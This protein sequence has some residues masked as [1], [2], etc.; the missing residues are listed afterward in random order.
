MQTSDSRC[1][2]V[3][4]MMSVVACWEAFSTHKY[5]VP[6]GISYRSNES[7]GFFSGILLCNMQLRSLIA[8]GQN[9]EKK[10]KNPGLSGRVGPSPRGMAST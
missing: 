3:D 6:E 8:F 10:M 7:L 4:G 1:R 5:I 2:F 9:R